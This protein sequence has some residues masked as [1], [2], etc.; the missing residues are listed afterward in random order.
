MSSETTA[1]PQ[2]VLYIVE[3]FRAPSGDVSGSLMTAS[4]EVI[5]GHMSSSPEW[6]RADLTHNFG[7]A[8]SLAERFGDFGLVYVGLGDELPGEIAHH[9]NAPKTK[10]DD[11]DDS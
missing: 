5:H 10:T 2:T 1:E 9:F 8:K 3:H 6:L 11:E 4:G 7:R